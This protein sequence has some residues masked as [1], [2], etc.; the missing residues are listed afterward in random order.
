MRFIA[1]IN[2]IGSQVWAFLILMTGIGAALLFH[3]AGLDIGI[4][5]GIIGAGVNMFNSIWKSQPEHPTQPVE[6]AQPK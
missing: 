4:A 5:A 6:P 3:R 2:A 1:A